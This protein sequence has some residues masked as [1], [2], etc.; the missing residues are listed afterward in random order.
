MCSRESGFPN[1]VL[2]F[3]S[4]PGS[5]CGFHSLWRFQ[6]VP[7]GQPQVNCGR[8]FLPLQRAFLLPPV[9]ISVPT[10]FT[11][12]PAKAFKPLLHFRH[13]S[14]GSHLYCFCKYYSSLA[15]VLTFSP[16]LTGMLPPRE[17]KSIVLGHIDNSEKSKPI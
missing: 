17:V 6:S 3:L 16:L 8:A 14:E 12:K 11:E 5:H 13:S 7:Q 1:S 4:F 9:L 2:G 15:Q 10:L